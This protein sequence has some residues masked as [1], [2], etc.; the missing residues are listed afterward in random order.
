MTAGGK[1][2][3]M[4]LNVYLKRGEETVELDS[5]KY[6]DHLFKVG[7]FRSSYNRAGFNY[8]VKML[9][10][11][12]LYSLFPDASM[13]NY[14]FTLSAEGWA[15]ARA[16]TEALLA[17]LRTAIE[18]AGR[19]SVLEVCMYAHAEPA[20]TEREALDTFKAKLA[21]HTESALFDA[22]SCSEGTFYLGDPVKAKAFIPGVNAIGRP[23]VFVVHE[24]DDPYTWYAEALEIV[25]ETVNH[26]L[27]DDDPGAFRLMWSG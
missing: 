11:K 13:D 16:A 10:G 17:K 26:V 2:I 15:R 1:E 23:C 14:D 9:T 6:P 25:L 3:D 21:S 12:D 4:G 22:F 7:Y 27:A 18:E 5:S 8:V 20:K 19:L 24:A